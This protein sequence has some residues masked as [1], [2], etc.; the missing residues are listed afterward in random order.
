MPRT[1]KFTLAYDGTAYRGWQRQAWGV[2]VQGLL[3]EALSRIEGSPVTVHGAGRT[4]AGVHALG[5][6]ASAVAATT[7]DTRRLRRALNATLPPDV[8]VVAVED[9]PEG[10]HARFSAKD[11]TY[12]Y[13]IFEGEVQP[14]FARGWSWHRTYRLD[15]SAMDQAA[16]ALVGTHDWSVFQSSGTG[17][18]SAVRTLTHASVRVEPVHAGPIGLTDGRAPALA[19]SP[20][21]TDGRFIVFRVEANGFLRHMVRAIAGTLVEIGEGR[22]A[23][24]SI[25][26]LIASRDRVSAGPTAPALGLVLVRVDYPGTGRV[27]R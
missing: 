23:A 19:E 5:Q 14:P 8:R 10:F 15:L 11:K 27:S 25:L 21:D 7:L 16:C 6:V 1:L 22:R 3:E 18:R 9:A 13:W 26:A 20:S 2:S 12:E 24:D 17:V 4:D